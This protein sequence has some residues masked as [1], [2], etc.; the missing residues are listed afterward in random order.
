MSSQQKN[1]KSNEIFLTYHKN[2]KTYNKRYECACLLYFNHPKHFSL[3]DIV[4]SKKQQ[5]YAIEDVFYHYNKSI[6]QGLIKSSDYDLDSTSLLVC[7]TC[8]RTSDNEL[9]GSKWN[10]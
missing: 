9:N 1:N 7:K 2:N 10:A 5:Q 8:G 3:A 6:E 4:L